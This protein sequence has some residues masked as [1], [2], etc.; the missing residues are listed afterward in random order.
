MKIHYS[1][2]LNFGA[3]GLC[4]FT[5]KATRNLIR[6][7]G[8]GGGNLQVAASIPVKCIVTGFPLILAAKSL[9]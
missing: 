9:T 4:A 8:G 2:V 7:L 1:A 6:E 5:T 3:T